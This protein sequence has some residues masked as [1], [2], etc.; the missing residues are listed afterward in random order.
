MLMVEYRIEPTHSVIEF[1]ARES[2]IRNR[3]A[4]QDGSYAQTPE[5]GI[6]M[7]G[8]RLNRSLAWV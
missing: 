6:E 8:L 7:R 1:T 2:F 4:A 3:L 5:I